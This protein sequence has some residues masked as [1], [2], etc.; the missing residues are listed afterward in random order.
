M[1][2]RQSPEANFGIKGTLASL[3]ISWGFGSEVRMMSS[4][5]NDA[6]FRTATR[7]TANRNK[8]KVVSGRPHTRQDYKRPL[9]AAVSDVDIVFALGE[10]SYNA[11]A[12]EQKH[13]GQ[14]PTITQN[15][16]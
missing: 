7:E 6:D 5:K 12:K 2:G 9:V 1:S 14:Q 15:N 13:S 11:R 16:R 8:L 10:K 4:D 3:L